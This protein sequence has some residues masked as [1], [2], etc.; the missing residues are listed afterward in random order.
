MCRPSIQYLPNHHKKL[1]EVNNI[2]F[3]NEET[4][5][6]K[7]QNGIQTQTQSTPNSVIFHDVM[8]S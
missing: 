1:C 2:K 8:Q 5:A 6:S 4:E 3:S 7:C